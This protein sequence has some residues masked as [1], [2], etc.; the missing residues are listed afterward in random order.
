MIL[1]LVPD[2]QGGD[3]LNL[4]VVILVLVLVRAVKDG[5]A[6]NVAADTVVADEE[7][8]VQLLSAVVTA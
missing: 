2:D 7:V 6:K 8:L 5:F 1:F 3:V 4:S